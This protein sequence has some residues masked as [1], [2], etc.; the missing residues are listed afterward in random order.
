MQNILDSTYAAAL[1]I[2]SGIAQSGE[3]MLL[4]IAVALLALLIALRSARG[5]Q[6]GKGE[7]ESS[8]LLRSGLQG[9]ITR[10]ER[11]LNELRTE[12]LRNFALLSQGKMEEAAAAEEV[13][14]SSEI[15]PLAEEQPGL[16]A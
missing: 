15:E 11:D 1:G 3:I 14:E 16:G 12:T 5:T 10:I 13:K 6:K 9:K 4:T 8:E 7:D 2:S